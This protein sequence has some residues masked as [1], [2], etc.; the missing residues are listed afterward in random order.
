MTVQTTL[1]KFAF[2][3]NERSFLLSS[4][5]LGALK[6]VQVDFVITFGAPQVALHRVYGSKLVRQ[7]GF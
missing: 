4:T 2:V 5:H 1:Q 3:D 7:G 6:S